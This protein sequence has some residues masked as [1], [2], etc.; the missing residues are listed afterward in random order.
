MNK[1]ILIITCSLLLLSA[2]GG[3][4]SEDSL[5]LDSDNDTIANTQDNC[6]SVPNTDQID[7]D[8]DGIGDACETINL[9]EKALEKI[10]QYAKSRGTTLIPNIQDYIDAGVVGVTSEKLTEVNQTIATLNEED[11]DTQAEIQKILDNLNIVIPDFDGDGIN[12][13]LDNCPA[14]SNTD[15]KDSDNDGKGD[16]CDLVLLSVNTSN[17]TEN[18]AKITWDLNTYATGYVKYGTTN[19]YG[20]KTIKEN[21]FSFKNHRQSISSLLPDTTYHYQV[22]S[23]SAGGNTVISED[24][25]F[26]TSVANTLPDDDNDGVANNIDN[27]PNIANPDQKDTDSDGQGDACGIFTSDLPLL[28]LGKHLSLIKGFNRTHPQVTSES[29]DEKWAEVLSKG[30]KVGRIQLDWA[31]LEPQPNQYNKQLLEEKLLEMEADGLQSFVML[32]TIDSEEFTI[33]LDLTDNTS[34]TFLANNMQF[35]D[36]IILARFRKLLDWVVPMIVSHKGWVLA[37]GNEPGNLLT[38]FPSTAPS[39]VNFLRNSRE[40]AHLID[41]NLA[42]TMT[43]AYSNVELGQPFHTDFLAESDV[44]SFNY[45]AFNTNLFFD[46][47][48]TTVNQEIDDMLALAGKKQLILQELGAAAGFENQTSPMGAS[49]TGQQEFFKTVFAKMENEPRFRAAVIFQLVDWEPALIDEFYTQPLIEEG[50]ASLDFIHRFAESLETTGLIRYEDGSSRPV[51]LTVLN[52]I[53]IFSD[54]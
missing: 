4:D 30:M 40:H 3:S 45:Y 27:C 20:Q 42:I 5:S 37:V 38:D 19:N 49:L 13:D 39:F 51:W 52:Q 25:T 1:L 7:S 48:K 33:P 26:K 47:A 10:S 44:A 28:S 35:D 18:S 16:V 9:K 36:P 29:M 17:I 2:C 15:Q 53:E 43:L 12:N 31:E 23:T 54:N 11:V 8:G 14:V 21:S 6:P 46:N 24:K 32:S 50:L 41:A 22:I 34:S